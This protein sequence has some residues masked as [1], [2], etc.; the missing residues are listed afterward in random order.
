MNVLKSI[1]SNS[2]SGD[3]TGVA[4]DIT[5]GAPSLEAVGL[6]WGDA[7][8]SSTTPRPQVQIVT[9]MNV[10]DE[11]LLRMGAEMKE[12]ARREVL[13]SLEQ[14]F[15]PAS[16]L[17]FL[18][19]DTPTAFTLNQAQPETKSTTPL[20][21][22]DSLVTRFKLNLLRG[23]A[24]SVSNNVVKTEFSVMAKSNPQQ[25]LCQGRQLVANVGADPKFD[26]PTQCS[27]ICVPRGTGKLCTP[28][29]FCARPIYPPG[30]TDRHKVRSFYYGVASVDNT[31]NLDLDFITV[32]DEPR[33]MN[34]FAYSDCN[35]MMNSKSWG[36]TGTL[37][38]AGNRKTGYF[39]VMISNFN[40]FVDDHGSPTIP[41]VW[42]PQISVPGIS[43]ASTRGDDAPAE[44]DSG[45]PSA[46]P[47]AKPIVI[48][49]PAAKPMPNLI[50]GHLAHILGVPPPIF[51]SG[52]SIV[53]ASKK[54]IRE[55][56]GGDRG[57]PPDLS[58]TPPLCGM[59]IPTQGSCCTTP[60]L[61]SL[62]VSAAPDRK[63]F[64]LNG[65][66]NTLVFN[67]TVDPRHQTASTMNADGNLVFTLD[68]SGP[69][70]SS[71]SISSRSR[72]RGN[73]TWDSVV[74]VAPEP[75]SFDFDKDCVLPCIQ[76]DVCAP[77]LFCSKETSTHT[78]IFAVV[79]RDT[80]VTLVFKELVRRAPAQ[81]W[82][83]I[84]HEDVCPGPSVKPDDTV[85]GSVEVAADPSAGRY[86][87]YLTNVSFGAN[88]FRHPFF[89]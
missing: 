33:S 51:L 1:C 67:M 50:P 48:V 18:D 85:I 88:I 65:V 19:A 7:Q 29:M 3:A 59:N 35:R 9:S 81:H 78:M 75:P 80:L 46:K 74:A 17:M 82:S 57:A 45:G 43:I 24:L 36:A 63:S 60:P 28:M 26:I 71:V 12:R 14:D 31:Y 25:I 66:Q 2:V 37:S 61:V 34:I 44:A 8:T 84:N 73:C 42:L 58:E 70:Y 39:Q 83:A 49:E 6:G 13:A 47:F 89:I 27:Q 79:S 56:G 62:C 77:H 21:S 41:E 5:V 23:E 69:L 22:G 87:V 76:E 52:A 64:Q 10:T 32:G 54:A 72:A 53:A 16:S 68:N 15:G 30:V 40:F 55:G 11:V 86:R 38:A 4:M 20:A